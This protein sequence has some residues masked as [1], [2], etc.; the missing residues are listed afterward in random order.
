MKEETGKFDKSGDSASGTKIS[1]G[2]VDLAFDQPSVGL[3]TKEVSED[4]DGGKI[5]PMRTTEKFYFPSNR[6][7]ILHHLGTMAISAAFPTSEMVVATVDGRPAILPGGLSRKEVS[8]LCA[9]IAERFPVLAEL[10]T[11]LNSARIEVLGIDQIAALHFRS[12]EEADEFR[13][14]SV[15]EV[16]TDD[17]ILHV[18][19]ELFIL[20]CPPRFVVEHVADPIA[21]TAARRADKVAGAIISLLELGKASPECWHT[22]GKLLGHPD[23]ICNPSLAVSIV[24]NTDSSGPSTTLDGEGRAVVEAFIADSRSRSRTLLEAV[25]GGLQ[26]S[27]LEVDSGTQAKWQIWFDIA[28]SVLSN[29]SPLSGNI[30]TDGGV[31]PLRAALVAAMADDAESISS[32][33]KGQAPAGKKVVTIAA[34]LVGFKTGIADTSWTRKKPYR[35]L[36]SLLVPALQLGLRADAQVEI[37][38]I[39]FAPHETL[40]SSFE[41]YWREHVLAEW[42]DEVEQPNAASIPDIAVSE[43]HHSAVGLDAWRTML[44]SAGYGFALNSSTDAVSS[45]ITTP[46][47]E[48][49]FLTRYSDDDGTRFLLACPVIAPYKMKAMGAVLRVAATPGLVWRAAINLDKQGTL[50]L[51]LKEVPGKPEFEEY[52]KALEFALGQYCIGKAKAKARAKAKPKSS[53]SSNTNV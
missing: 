22:I 27:Q 20:E 47:G 38:S 53:I 14:R 35:Q 17:F 24:C 40:Q 25:L 5:A 43:P 37:P 39:S 12:A 45:V 51:D 21:T 33:L 13:F 29:Q 41:L 49:V 2:Q 11:E 16:A 23:F 9:G 30:L 7:H 10:T 34:A 31:I 18:S 28:D 8:L 4:G 19:P 6:E 15:D 32:F 46:R 1:S 48:S 50:L 26:R 36:L 42:S 52:C 3:L 44:E